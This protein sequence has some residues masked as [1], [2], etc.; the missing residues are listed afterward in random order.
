MW[1]SNIIFYR[2]V[3]ICLLLVFLILDLDISILVFNKKRKFFFINLF[4]FGK[5]LDFLDFVGKKKVL[6]SNL[7][8]CEIL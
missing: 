2:V 4:V 7:I 6:Y 8:I 5:R 1:E 3:Y